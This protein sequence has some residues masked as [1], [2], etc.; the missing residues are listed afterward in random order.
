MV[1]W[2]TRM[3]IDVDVLPKRSQLAFRGGSPDWLDKLYSRPAEDRL[4]QFELPS[5]SIHRV[6]K[7]IRDL[8]GLG[9]LPAFPLV[10]RKWRAG[11]EKILYTS[12]QPEI[13]QPEKLLSTLS[14]RPDLAQR[15]R[16]LR[17]GLTS[18]TGIADW[19][20]ACGQQSSTYDL[21]HALL[22]LCPNVEFLHIM[23][24]IHESLP[25]AHAWRFTSLHALKRITNLRLE[26]VAAAEQGKT[27]NL[28]AKSSCNA[29]LSD[30][31]TNLPSLTVLRITTASSVSMRDEH[32]VTLEPHF[33]LCQELTAL[34][35]SLLMPIK[36][37][38]LRDLIAASAS[39]LRQLSVNTFMM[40]RSDFE[41]C[42]APCA[43]TLSCLAISSK[44]GGSRVRE[45]QVPFWSEQ[46]TF[47]SVLEVFKSLEKLSLVDAHPVEASFSTL[48]CLP[49]ANTLRHLSLEGV[50]GIARMSEALESVSLESFPL[51]DVVDLLVPD[52]QAQDTCQIPILST[53]R[54]SCEDKMM[55]FDGHSCDI[56]LPDSYATADMW[57][58]FDRRRS[59]IMDTYERR[60]CF[61]HSCNERSA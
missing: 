54:R 31:I 43:S 20:G 15:M 53:F 3:S 28:V 47:V 13:M 48:E 22:A 9:A 27:I 21:C 30:L 35:L 5:E 38:D 23:F 34:H 61:R 57:F 44:L 56:G 32:V 19:N 40:S 8:E 2:Y 10:N 18:E 37:I 33:E 24:D 16:Y 17:W 55:W 12:Q 25:L 60:V 45:P 1:C 49:L 51:L 46:D 42:M 14:S 6:L 41:D 26:F 58:A 29:D 52:T 4:Y 7:Q 39:S 59:E 50:G 36:G 11:V